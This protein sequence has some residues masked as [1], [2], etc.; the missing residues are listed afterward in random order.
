MDEND[1][2]AIHAVHNLFVCDGG[3]ISRVR[4]T[5]LPPPRYAWS[6]GLG[7]TDGSWDRMGGGV[8]PIAGRRRAADEEIG[9][10]SCR[11]R[12]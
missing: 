1:G 6:E 8:R 11:E 12:V 10:A 9:R 4:I 5:C 2:L 7:G 3:F